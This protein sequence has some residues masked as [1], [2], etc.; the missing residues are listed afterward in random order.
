MELK[1]NLTAVAK[2]ECPYMERFH[3]RTVL[4]YKVNIAS[5]SFLLSIHYIWKHIRINKTKYIKRILF[6]SVIVF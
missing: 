3:T 5:S 1:P 2:Q 6:I 4:G